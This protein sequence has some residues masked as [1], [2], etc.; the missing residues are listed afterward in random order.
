MCGAGGDLPERTDNEGISSVHFRLVYGRRERVPHPQ[1]S[2]TL[3]EGLRRLKM[4][5]T[6][7]TELAH[8]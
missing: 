7:G 8:F 1:S 2:L 3:A 4:S 5:A 6:R